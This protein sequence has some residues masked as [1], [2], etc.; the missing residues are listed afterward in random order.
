[1]NNNKIIEAVFC[2]LLENSEYLNTGIVTGIC[3]KCDRKIR[4]N[5]SGLVDFHKVPGEKFN[6]C[7]GSQNK[8]RVS[9]FGSHPGYVEYFL[10][11]V[12]PESVAGF[13]LPTAEADDGEDQSGTIILIPEIE[14]AEVLQRIRDLT[15]VE[16]FMSEGM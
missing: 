13:G 3:P 11:R 6:E 16:P 10:P 8:P 5:S 7:P 2:K 9:V 15:G 4:L 12:T 14:E 1:M